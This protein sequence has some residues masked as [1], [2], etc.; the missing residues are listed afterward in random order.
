MTVISFID[1]SVLCNLVP[2]PGR[3]QNAE[4]VRSEMSARLGRK[5][6]FI[7]PVTS[8]V[9]TGNFIAQL[10]DGRLRRETATRLHDIL[11]LVCE[12]KAPWVLHDLAWDRDFLQQLLDGADTLTSYVEH[13][14]SQL[15]AGDLLIINERLQY[16]Q[17]SQI[18]AAIWTLDE[19]LGSY[20]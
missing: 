6:R 16:E 17:R 13:A 8:V 11:R 7:L 9:E 10:S 20:S 19:K 5:E 15:G 1:T 3:D 2:V 14:A 4:R 18:R 12:G